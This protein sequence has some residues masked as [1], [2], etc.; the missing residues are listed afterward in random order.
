M[1][2]GTQQNRVPFALQ[3]AAWPENKGVVRDLLRDAGYELT[4]VP[5]GHFM[6]LR[7]GGRLFVCCNPSYRNNC[8]STK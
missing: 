1:V 2:A 6:L 4:S 7:L 5:D 3:P 8:W